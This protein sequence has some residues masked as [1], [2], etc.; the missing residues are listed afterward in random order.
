[1]LDFLRYGARTLFGSNA[2]LRQHPNTPAVEQLRT[3]IETLTARVDGLV[4]AEA[5]RTA[6]H[7]HM[8]DRLDRLY[9]RIA[10][11]IARENGADADPVT[12]PTDNE[13][14][15]SLRSRLGR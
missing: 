3:S 5:L 14:V 6:E 8:V 2:S 4:R 15:L 9:K 13:S 11:R 10:A 7:A 1:M 12:P